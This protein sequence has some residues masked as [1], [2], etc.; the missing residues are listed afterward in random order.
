MKVPFDWRAFSPEWRFE[1]KFCVNKPTWN[2]TGQLVIK[3][4]YAGREEE[5]RTS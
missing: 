3:G 2:T 4:T 5:F 1:P